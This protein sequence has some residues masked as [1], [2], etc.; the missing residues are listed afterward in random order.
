LNGNNYQ[1]MRYILI[2]GW[3]FFLFN[4]HTNAQGGYDQIRSDKVRTI[5]GKNFFEHQVKKGQT[6]Y[7]ISKAYNITMDE[8]IDTNP[9]I[10]NGLKANQILLIPIHEPVIPAELPLLIEPAVMDP[11]VVEEFVTLLED[12]LN[13]LP[14]ELSAQF[15]CGMGP[16]SKKDVYNVALMIHLFLNEADSINTNGPTQ[17]EIDRYNSLKYIQFYEGFLIAVDSLRKT[18]LTINLYVYSLETNLNATYALLKKPE[19]AQM[20]L[21]IGMLFNRNFEIVASWARDRQI[22]VVSPISERESQVEGNPMVIKLRPSYNSEG[23]ALAEYLANNYRSTHTLLIRSWEEEGKKMADQI[24]ANCKAIGLDIVAVSQDDLI[25]KLNRG[26]ENAVVVV[27][28]QKSFVMNVLSQLNAD[29]NGYQFTVFGL[30]RWDQFD[31][32]DYQYLEKAGAH[33]FVPSWIDYTDPAVK[34]IVTLFRD[35]YKTEPESLAFQGYDVAWYFL[36]A[37]KHY[38]A[39][40]NHCLTEISIRPLQTNYKFRRVNGN[41]WENHHWELFRYDN[42]TRTP[43]N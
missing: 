34:R 39:G 9:E 11:P 7:S 14:G 43:L 20:D 1:I 32:I 19:M 12:T 22:P 35:K 29:T 6:L 16:D 15:P 8:V 42:Y 26:V 38:G 18:G 37:L 28:Q 10:K 21:I 2:I 31:G 33:I 40:F 30:P 41:G 17:K 4:T 36:N 23:I 3:F 27:S 13:S 5:N 25:G 24:Y